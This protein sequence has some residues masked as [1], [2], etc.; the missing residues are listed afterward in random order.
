[1]PLFLKYTAVISLIPAE[2]DYEA[3]LLEP[4]EVKAPPPL[5]LF[6]HGKITECMN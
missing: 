2:L 3:I 5:V 4:T 6:L 1:M